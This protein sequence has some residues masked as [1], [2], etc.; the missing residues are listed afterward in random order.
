MSALDRYYSR[1]LEIMQVVMEK[2]RG[3]IEKAAEW[4]SQAVLEDRLFYVFG[5][6]AHSIMSA[7]E[8]F[9]RA[10]NLCNSS[11]VFP[12]GVTDFDGHPK[13]EKLLGFS[14]MIFDYYGI[15]NGDLLFICNV[16]GIN[17]MTIDAAMEARKRGIRTVGITSV[18]F[19]KAVAPNISQRHPSN[20]NLY[21][22]V[23]LYIDAHVPVGDAL[24]GLEG[25]PVP[26]GPGSTYPMILIVNSVVIRA[27][28]LVVQQGGTPPVMKSANVA[29]GIE[30][31]EQFVVRY[32]KRIRHFS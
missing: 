14:P 28:E 2:E 17:H 9:M 7:M 1:I 10:G 19:S 11:G 29:G 18:E 21:E 31:N 3:V 6:G 27:I 20:M 8:L 4:V 30:Y 25:V 23:D 12:P 16:N 24:I 13:T 26:V 22:L 32:Q 15:K 5:T